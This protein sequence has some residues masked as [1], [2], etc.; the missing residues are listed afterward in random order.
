VA[1]QVAATAVVQVD[2]KIENKFEI[3]KILKSI[4]FFWTVAAERL[5]QVDFFEVLVSRTRTIRH[6]K[7]VLK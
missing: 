1:K 6:K 3:F 2:P 4:S 7:C 5:P